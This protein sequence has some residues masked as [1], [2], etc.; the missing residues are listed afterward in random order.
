MPGAIRQGDTGDEL[1]TGRLRRYT[2]GMHKPGETLFLMFA[3]ALPLC[4]VP[5]WEWRRGKTR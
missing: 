2:G 5:P 1:D 3:L 4:A